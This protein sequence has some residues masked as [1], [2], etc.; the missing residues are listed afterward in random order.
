MRGLAFPPN[1]VFEREPSH[2]Y[3]APFQGG[4]EIPIDPALGGI[5][6]D[7]AIM[8]ESSTGVGRGNVRNVF[9]VL[10]R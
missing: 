9:Q 2:E 6:I 8:G 7:P 5:A 4:D 3:S 10:T 1:A